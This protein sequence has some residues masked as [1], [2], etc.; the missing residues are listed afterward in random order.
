MHV[1]KGGE[2]VAVG[3]GVGGGGREWLGAQ[4]RLEAKLRK[5]GFDVVDAFPV[6]CL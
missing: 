5:F 6:R 2:A 4:V 3:G 1:Y